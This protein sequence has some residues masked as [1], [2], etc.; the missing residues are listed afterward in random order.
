MKTVLSIDITNCG[1][2]SPSIRDVERKGIVDAA[3]L[4]NDRVVPAVHAVSVPL[5]FV[6]QLETNHAIH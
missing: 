2:K 5:S 6:D 4:T 1:T 3:D